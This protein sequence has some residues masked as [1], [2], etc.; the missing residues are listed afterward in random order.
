MSVGNGSVLN[1]ICPYFTMF[2]LAF[3]YS[4]LKEKASE[5][6]L[7]LDPFC[8][9]GT[10]N[11][12]ARML[13]LPSVGI[14]SSPVAVAISQAK[15]ART[16]PERIVCAA[17]RILHERTQTARVPVGEFWELAFHVDVL[18]VLC[19]L[20][21]GLLA[22]CRS[23]SRKA[24]R[25]ILLGAL[26]GPRNKTV[27]SY[28]SNQCTR[29]YAPK[30]R[31]AVKYWKE[32][33]L[34]P[35]VVDVMSLIRRRAERYYAE[36]AGDAEG[37]IV[38]GDSRQ[39]STVTRA[40]S[41]GKVKWVITSP[42]YYGLRT[43]IPDQWLRMWLLGGDSTVDYS[44]HGQLAHSTQGSF[45]EQ[46]SQVW[47]NVANVCADDARLVVRFGSISDR[48]VDAL[49]LAAASLEESGWVVESTRPAGSASHGRRQALHFAGST[50]GP[51]EEFDLWARF[52]SHAG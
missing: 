30:P 11:L 5:G 48:K 22:D 32:H 46:L 52:G 23:N 15:I 45:K 24:L 42:P 29:T 7:V 35:E 26:H 49:A 13:G 47:A 8:G 36:N 16:T 9:R 39:Q 4:I 37:L 31:Y 28:L 27:P 1:G 38:R 44:N 50:H 12:A 33:N 43:Y 2:P 20:R 17:E 3:P 34:Q 19:R 6:Q 41:C 25:A 51:R 14:D 18:Q 21:D 10:T 40:A